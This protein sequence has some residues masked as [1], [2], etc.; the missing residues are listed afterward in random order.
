[1]IEDLYDLLAGNHL[2]NVAVKDAK[3][4]LLS[5]VVALAPMSG[6]ADIAEHDGVGEGDDERE[7]PVEYDKHSHGTCD[8][9]PVFHHGGK[10]VVKGIRDSIDIVC[11]IAHHIS[12]LS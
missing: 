1:M 3:A 12:A 2:L 10:A 5:L 6:V 8:L 7:S 11:I 9:Y 4:P